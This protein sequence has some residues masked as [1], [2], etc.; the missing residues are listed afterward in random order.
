MH[1]FSEERLVVLVDKKDN[2]TGIADKMEAH[3]KAL[4]HRAVSV[5]VFSSSG[6][7]VLQKR[8]RDKYHSGGLWTNACCTH[9]MPGEAEHDSARRRLIEEMGLSCEMRK[10]FTFIY[11]EKVDADLYEHELDHVYAGFT[12]M[13]ATVDPA[14]VEDW[15]RMT[16]KELDDDVRRNPHNY[17]VWF[18]KIYRKVHRHINKKP[19]KI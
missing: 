8:A 18:R 6:E 13:D 16:Y 11:K 5:F 1:T 7:W 2:I 4:L 17:T 19:I 9:P 14:E 12:D 3:R 15:K 10:L